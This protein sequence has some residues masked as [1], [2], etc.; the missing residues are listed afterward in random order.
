MSYQSKPPVT[1]SEVKDLS[2]AIF[3]DTKSKSRAC[4]KVSVLSIVYCYSELFL[5]CFN[6]V[7]FVF[8]NYTQI[9]KFVWM[10]PRK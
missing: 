1:E 3:N 5:C 8:K 2:L 4:I 7:V 9:I 6:F 10:I